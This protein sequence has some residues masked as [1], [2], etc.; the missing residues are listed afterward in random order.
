MTT[1]NKCNFYIAKGIDDY[2]PYMYYGTEPPI[3]I[4]DKTCS[5]PNC[6]FVG[7]FQDNPIADSIKNGEI[8]KI[9]IRRE[10]KKK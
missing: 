7:S 1:K 9:Y 2:C 4:D 8:I 3:F 10:N 6:T 5:T